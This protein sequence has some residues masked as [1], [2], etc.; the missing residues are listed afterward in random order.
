MSDLEKCTKWNGQHRGVRFEISLHGEHREWR[1][2]GTWCYYV[3]VSEV[4][5][6]AESRERFELAPKH[7]EKG[8]VHY[9]YNSA[10]FASLEWHCGITYYE[11]LGGLDGAKRAYKMGCDYA[12]YW[13]EGRDYSVGS[14]EFD[15]RRTIDELLTHVKLLTHCSWCGTYADESTMQVWGSG[16]IER[17]CI[18]KRNAACPEAEPIAVVV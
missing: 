16:W 6:P 10:W 2:R 15:V 14:V 4:Q 18:Q 5:L 12:H 8:R 7:D 13:D 9:D 1:P 3:L 11:K 17:G